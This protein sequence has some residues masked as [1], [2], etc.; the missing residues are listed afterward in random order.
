MNRNIANF[1]ID[2]NDNLN[3]DQINSFISFGYECYI[4]SNR[5]L[6]NIPVGVFHYVI[7]N[8]NQIEK[9]KNSIYVPNNIYCKKIFNFDNKEYFVRGVDGYYIINIIDVIER[10]NNLPILIFLYKK[11]KPN[12]PVKTEINNIMLFI[13]NSI[14]IKKSITETINKFIYILGRPTIYKT[15]KKLK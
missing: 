6:S 9:F 14:V 13:S 2:E 11:I 15:K 10:N 12:K 8:I 7:N 4:Y 1:Y 3:I 5:K